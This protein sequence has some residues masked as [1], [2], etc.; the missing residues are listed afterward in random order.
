M[1]YTTNFEGSFEF[2]RELTEKEM[3]TINEF[4]E[5]RHGELKPYSGMPGFWCDWST[6]DGKILSWNGSEKFYNYT[7]WLQYL[8]DNFFES[9]NI[10]LNGKVF[11]S[12]E[13][14]TDVG[15][16]EVENNIIK[17]HVGLFKV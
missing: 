7:E 14:V 12:G 13:R 5:E 17:K 2:S 6:P 1:G 3:D 10:K 16:I 15:T 8:I 4:S 11:W 9:W